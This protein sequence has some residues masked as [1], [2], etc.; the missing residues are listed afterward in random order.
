MKIVLSLLIYF[1]GDCLSKLLLFKWFS[2]LY[3]LY[4]KIMLI[5]SNLDTTDKV[6]KSAEK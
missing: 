2:F 4:S 1:V 3:P 5:S 6:W